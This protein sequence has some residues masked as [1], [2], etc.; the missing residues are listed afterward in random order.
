MLNAHIKRRGTKM[1]QKT[2][3]INQNIPLVPCMY[4]FANTTEQL[5]A[6][7]RCEKGFGGFCPVH[8]MPF[9]DEVIY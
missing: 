5:I 3:N 9:N 8:D 1:N 7:T 6:C 4:H 2:E